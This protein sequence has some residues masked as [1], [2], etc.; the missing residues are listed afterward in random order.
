MMLR[1]VSTLMVL[2]C[3]ATAPAATPRLVPARIVQLHNVERAAVG[4]PPLVYDE[5]L[6]R[7]AAVWARRLAAAGR[8]WHDP[9]NRAEGENI[10]M[11]TRGAFT[12]DEMVGGWTEEKALLPALDRWLEIHPRASHYTMM[13]WHSV[14]RVG[15]A[16]ASDRRNDFLVCRYSPPGNVVGQVPVPHP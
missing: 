5:A 12:L 13:I 16:I 11:G 3:A 6:A 15:C 4:T 8:I 10:W 14:A 7:D 1:L 2:A 9:Q